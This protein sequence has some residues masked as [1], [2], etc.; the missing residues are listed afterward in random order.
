MS[1]SLRDLVGFEVRDL[2]AENRAEY[3]IADKTDGVLI[4]RVVRGS[5]A[6]GK[7]VVPGMI[8][9]EVNQRP[10]A[11]SAEISMLVEQAREAGRPAVLFKLADAT[12]ARQFLAVRL[13]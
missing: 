8:I 2:D 6:A 12:G 3:G 5:D 9:E 11:D 7:G 10:V 13:N 4:S 1:S